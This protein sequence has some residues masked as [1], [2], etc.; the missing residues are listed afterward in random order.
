MYVGMVITYSKS[1]DKPGK[2]A[3]PA[4]GQ[5]RVI[6]NENDNFEIP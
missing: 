3:N 1:K 2:V 6:L 5:L 4:H